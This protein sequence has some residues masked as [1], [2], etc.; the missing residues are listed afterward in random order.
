MEW[1]LQEF[2][3]VDNTSNL[4]Y[5]KMANNEI[6]KTFN[7]SPGRSFV[8]LDISIESGATQQVIIELFE[9]ECPKTCKNF[10]SLCKG[11]TTTDKRTIGY[12]DS[13]I[14]RVVKGMFVQAGDI[15][16][17]KFLVP[18]LTFYRGR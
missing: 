6:V 14:K 12:K 2:R 7:K 3:Y 8:Y 17:S 13:E 5:K 1:A 11:F 15:N 16:S 4:L 10:S 18:I 9:K